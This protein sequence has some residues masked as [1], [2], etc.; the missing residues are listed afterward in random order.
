MCNN[1][2]SD[3]LSKRSIKY[4][5]YY[6]IASNNTKLINS[7]VIYVNKELKESLY[8][9]S[10]KKD[11][12]S[13]LIK[14]RPFYRQVVNRILNSVERNTMKEALLWSEV[15]KGER[16]LKYKKAA[17]VKSPN[18][19]EEASFNNGYRPN[20]QEKKLLDIEEECIKQQDRILSYELCVINNKETNE[21]IKEFISL[22][23]NTP[24]V[25]LLIR[26]Y[27]NGE[28]YS[29]LSSK[30]NYSEEYIPTLRKRTIEEL[31]IIL[32]ISL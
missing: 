24:G 10:N 11:E 5:K 31:A 29:D 17:T 14:E 22:A 9:D 23:T 20:T 32:M 27:I 16:I 6:N 28:K 30:L 21:L 1:K 7:I 2:S 4:N 12:E 3:D 26:H 25:E 13:Y 15:E 8:K 18:Y 19:G